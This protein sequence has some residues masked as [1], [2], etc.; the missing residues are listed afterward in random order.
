M[1]LIIFSKSLPYKVVMSMLSHFG[2]V[3][4][5]QSQLGEYSSLFNGRPAYEFVLAG[6]SDRSNVPPR[7]MSSAG[8]CALFGSGIDQILHG[9]ESP[10]GKPSPFHKPALDVVNRPSLN[11]PEG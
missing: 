5:W 7:M 9:A 8:C 4:Y 3:A 10:N 1:L 6:L 2:V 11:L